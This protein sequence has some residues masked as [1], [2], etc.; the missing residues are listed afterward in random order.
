MRVLLHTG[1]GGVGKTSLALA[2]ALAAADRGHRVFLLSTDAAHSLGDAL[3]APVGPR[4]VEVA[5]GVVAQEVAALAEVDRSWAR[6]RDWLV[7]LLG[8]GA[9]GGDALVA[10]EVLALPG[11]E[12]LVSLRALREVEKSGDFDVCVVDCAPTGSMLRLLRFPDAL[13]WFMQ[14]FFETERRAARLLRPI[15]NRIGAGRFVAPEAVW[16]AAESLY[17]EI[18]EVRG[19]L[20][21]GKRTSARLVLC[22]ARVV[23]DET[24][25]AFAY[26]SLHGIAC[27]AVLVNRVLPSG[28]GTGYF[29]GWA[30]R[31]RRELAEI[32]RSFPLPILT[33]PLLP[34]EPIGEAALRGL[35]AALYAGRDPARRFAEAHP[36]R[37]AKRDAHTVLAIDLPGVA[38]EEVDVTACG[39]DLIVSV[40]DALRRIAL[41]DSLSGRAIR[42]ARLE[43]GVL[44]IEFAP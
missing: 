23:V 22:P 18:R 10:E 15:A 7:G 38:R 32:E 31:E 21:D 41:P 9:E 8:D 30:A 3:G 16:S 4:A 24:R 34:R 2:T 43:G 37:L 27:D 44:E 25:R 26:L 39:D 12:E 36:L 11:L 28:A 33:A 14:G 42:A 35:A 13:R 17:D 40:R 20:L 6:I 19:I 29:G 1:K 5:R